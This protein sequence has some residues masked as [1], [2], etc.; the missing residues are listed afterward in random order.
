[1]SSSSAPK[2]KKNLSCVAGCGLVTLLVCIGFIIL[3]ITIH[4]NIDAQVRQWNNSL[5]KAT[6]PHPNAPVTCD[7]VPM[8]PG[9]I[10]DHITTLP[11]GNQ[12]TIHYSYDEQKQSQAQARLDAENT[13]L[14][15]Q[16]ADARPPIELMNVLSGLCWIVGGIA[17][18]LTLLLLFS[19]F[20]ALF[21]PSKKQPATASAVAAGQ[22]SAQT[23]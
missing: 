21:S 8:S 20:A 4:N 23:P 10:C 9:D 12:F 14:G 16:H 19:Y 15:I 2:E 18:L 5:V 13:R 1:M 6:D 17:G 11:S 22:E 7:N 3:A